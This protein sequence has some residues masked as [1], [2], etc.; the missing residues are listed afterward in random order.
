MVAV[1]RK[2]LNINCCW[3]ALTVICFAFQ[4]QLVLIRKRRYIYGFMP[5]VLCA[6][7]T[8]KG[9]ILRWGLILN[10][11]FFPSLLLANP[12][13]PPMLMCQCVT[14]PIVVA[15]TRALTTIDRINMDYEYEDLD[16]DS[17][18]LLRA[19]EVGLDLTRTVLVAP[20]DNMIEELELQ[21]RLEL[22][23]NKVVGARTIL[24]PI[25]SN[26]TH[27]VGVVIKLDEFNRALQIQYID[28]LGTSAFESDIPCEIRAILK[29]L[30]GKVVYIENLLL[31]SQTDRTASG[32]LTVENLTRVAQGN[33]NTE[34]AHEGSIREIRSHHIHLLEQLR[35]D[36]QFNYRQE[37]N[38]SERGKDKFLHMSLMAQFNDKRFF[39]KSFSLLCEEIPTN[40]KDLLLE[41]Q[42]LVSIKA[43][44]ST[45]FE[46]LEFKNLCD[47]KRIKK[48]GVDLYSFT[49]MFLNKDKKHP[50]YFATPTRNFLF[51]Q[52]KDKNSNVTLVPFVLSDEHLDVTPIQVE[53]SILP[54]SRQID[55]ESFLR[56]GIESVP[57]LEE[58][59]KSMHWLSTFNKNLP[60]TQNR[61]SKQIR[62]E[63]GTIIPYDSN[64]PNYNANFVYEKENLRIAVGEGPRDD[65]SFGR[66][67]KDLSVLKENMQNNEIIIVALGND[68]SIDR[69]DFIDYYARNNH[70]YS[71]GL[72]TYKV[73]SAPIQALQT[74][75]LSGYRLSVN[76]KHQITVVHVKCP[77]Y[78]IALAS[79][80]KNDI[81][82][83]Y[84]FVY[85]KKN[86]ILLFH[87]K[88]GKGRSGYFAFAAKLLDEWNRLIPKTIIDE[89]E[90]VQQLEKLYWEMRLR[91]PITPNLE[92]FKCAV[93]L[94]NQ[95]RKI[96]G[97]L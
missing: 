14:D 52:L 76:D 88:V 48:G 37:N 22:E 16:V 78:G 49:L 57:S 26:N 4:A 67:L 64:F 74:A 71:I 15:K 89:S 66:L 28:P 45:D 12:L 53:L 13:R 72:D 29:V 6:R 18:L 92:Q 46:T 80:N 86:V 63:I 60:I 54:N 1:L 97:Q 69:A 10:L 83:L 91:R 31:L 84:D 94:A 25:N 5:I 30:Y 44:V 34:I 17:L 73:V 27:W 95:L 81:A 8:Y 85:S 2:I 36:L 90:F 38:I 40:V 96:Q 79:L 55:T 39:S 61:D 21:L 87:C 77:D 93:Q 82:L 7:K 75:N 23:R 43:S 33:I 68:P 41:L 11:L 70:N 47:I 19:Q 62:E 50:G 42:R 56:E 3:L 20:L 59:I 35:P 65:K 58:R 51:S 32:P 9:F 24:I